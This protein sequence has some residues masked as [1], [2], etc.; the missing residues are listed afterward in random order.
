LFTTI[1]VKTFDFFSSFKL[2]ILFFKNLCN[3]FVVRSDFFSETREI[4][5]N[6]TVLLKVK[7]ILLN[8]I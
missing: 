3:V 1:L 4:Y 6:N 2:R 5:N 8:N 7:K